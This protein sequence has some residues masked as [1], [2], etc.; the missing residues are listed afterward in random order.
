MFNEPTL[1]LADLR[2]LAREA[3]M[4]TIVTVLPELELVRRQTEATR[5][6]RHV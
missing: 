1:V 3:I 5:I 4:Q 2:P 6:L